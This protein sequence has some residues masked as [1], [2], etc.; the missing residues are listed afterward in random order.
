[1]GPSPSEWWGELK[2][3]ADGGK[4]WSQ[5]NRLPEGIIGP[6]K[7]KPV[8]LTNGW[9]L[10]P[11]STEDHGWRVH[12]EFTADDGLTWERTEAL[13]DTTSVK[14]IQPAI[15]LHTGKIQLLCRSMMGKVLSAWSEDNGR[16]WSKLTPT[17]LPNPN[18]GIDA[19]TLKDS[20]FLLIYNHLRNGRNSLNG[21]ISDDGVEWKAAFLLENDQ[22]GKEFS[23]PAVIQDDN[24]L[25]HVTYTWNRKQI[26]HVVI[27]PSK[28]NA[29]PFE[30]G[31][32]PPSK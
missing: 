4:T 17:S 16:S 18:S 32:W 1:V 11:S 30:D 15:L 6:V 27:D 26:K 19:V 22:K 2:T 29:R 24:G 13:N 10:C 8:L 7:D 20:R 25:I 21:A 12:M 3:S 23:Y 28:I 31:E 9:L 5:A 14:A